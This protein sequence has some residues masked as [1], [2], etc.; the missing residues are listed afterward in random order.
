MAAA[1][2]KYYQVL[3]TFSFQTAQHMRILPT[4]TGQAKLQ[5]LQGI[6]SPTSLPATVAAA[7]G[8]Y[9]KWTAEESETGFIHSPFPL[10]DSFITS[11]LTK[12]GVQGSIRRW[13]YFPK[14]TCS[15]SNQF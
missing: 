3:H 11:K 5:H 15:P 1:M 12:G 9:P 13:T 6:Y 2:G 7:S 4:G 10:I 8:S 14:G